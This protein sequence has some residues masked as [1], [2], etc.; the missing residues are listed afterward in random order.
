GMVRA[1]IADP[2]LLPK[3][4]AGRADSVRPCV[5]ANVCINA[6]LDHKPLACMA[7]PDAGRTAAG[8]ADGSGNGRRAVVVG[9]GPA[10]LEAARRLAIGGWRA[11]LIEREARLGGQMAL[12]SQTPSRVEFLRLVDWWS[13]ECERL[14]VDVRTRAEADVALLARLAPDLVVVATGSRSV[15]APVPQR[16]NDLRQAGPYDPAPAGSHVLVRD[17]M[18]RLAALLTAERASLAAGRVTFV[19]SLL[20]PGEGDGLATVYPL[21][22]DV[23]ARGV[24]IIDRAKVTAIEGRRVLLKGVFGEARPHVEDVDLVVALVDAISVAGLAIEARE[25]GLTVATIGDAHLPRD[26]TSAVSDAARLVDDLANSPASAPRTVIAA[27]NADESEHEDR[28]AL[29]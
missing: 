18:G 3:S 20:H 29:Q 4:K 23:A 17:E 8:I 16:G 9:G 25:A 22:R 21:L 2:E 1:H 26:V 19:T 13:R 6:L 27:A 5:G 10:G 14:G 11:I 15:A 12:W 28:P 7:N 24:T